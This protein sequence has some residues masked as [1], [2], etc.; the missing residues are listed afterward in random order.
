MPRIKRLTQFATNFT[1]AVFLCPVTT[2]TKLFL[3]SPNKNSPDCS[4]L[5]SWIVRLRIAVQT[6]YGMMPNK[7]IYVRCSKS[8]AGFHADKQTQFRG[9][10]GFIQQLSP[11]FSPTPETLSTCGTFHSVPQALHWL[12]RT[13]QPAGR[14]EPC[15]S[16]C[17]LAGL[18]C[19]PLVACHRCSVSFHTLRK[20]L[21]PILPADASTSSNTQIA[22]NIL[23]SIAASQG[24][25]MRVDTGTNS[26]IS[27][28][29]TLIEITEY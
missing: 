16:S 22:F 11:M 29:S 21:V 9:C 18:V 1:A 14:V 17:G 12:G 4:E 19:Q 8:Q 10:F 5:S 26:G 13:P 3:H 2:K 25:T 27:T 23:S 20:F 6:I 7:S 15:M 28:N 24:S